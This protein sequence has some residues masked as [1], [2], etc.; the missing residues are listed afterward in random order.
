MIFLF[1]F[2]RASPFLRKDVLITHFLVIKF[3]RAVNIFSGAAF[4]ILFVFN[5]KKRKY[6]AGYRELI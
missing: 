1:F 2:I 5:E 6:K 4:A 3:A